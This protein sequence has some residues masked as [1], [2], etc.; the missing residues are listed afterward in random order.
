MSEPDIK[1]NKYEEF[2]KMN[3]PTCSQ[4]LFCTEHQHFNQRLM[5]CIVQK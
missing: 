1:Q 2:H 4:N 5:E 3:M